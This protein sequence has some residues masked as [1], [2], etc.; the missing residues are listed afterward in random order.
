M[1]GKRQHFIPRFLQEGFA[2]KTTGDASF[3]WVY[4]KGTPPFNANITNVGVEGHFYTDGDDTQVD[5]IITNVEE[6]F[7]NLIRRLRTT[8]P[9]AVSEPDLPRLIAHLEVRTR[10]VRENFLRTGDYLVSRLLDFMSDERAFADYMERKI[11]ENPSIIRNSLSNALAKHGLPNTLLEPFYQ[12]GVALLPTLLTQFKPFFPQ[13][14]AEIRSTLPKT[15]KDAAKTGH[16][17]ALKNAVAPAIRIQRYDSFSYALVD[18]VDGDLILGD[19][20]VLFHIEGAT[21]Y[22]ALFDKGEVI[23]AVF[24]PLT[25]GRILVGA[26]ESFNSLPPGLRQA[27]A[28]CSLEYFIAAQKSEANSLLKEQ[29]GE[30][31][32]I[33]KQEELEE[34]ISGF[35]KRGYS[36]GR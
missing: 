6:N 23:K 14:A 16:I 13:L 31:A 24:L 1:S 33:L 28:H 18:I 25:P 19:S 27:L 9:G 15:L 5:D 8:T 32:A 35:M 17:R 12:K 36:T 4:R 29:I 26:C 22:K 34:I 21:P 30:D 11:R 7:S 10:H 20:A 2:S 3:T